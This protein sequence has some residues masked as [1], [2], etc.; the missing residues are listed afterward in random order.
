VQLGLCGRGLE[1]LLF[2]GVEEGGEVVGESHRESLLLQSVRA[3]ER[4]EQSWNGDYQRDNR[5]SLFSLRTV[6]R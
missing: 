4:A 2:E 5:L 3:R 6:F 1:Q